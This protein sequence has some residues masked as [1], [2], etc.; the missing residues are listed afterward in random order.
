MPRESTAKSAAAP[1]NPP[2]RLRASGGY[3]GLRSFQV[4]T[5]VYDATVV[6]CNSWVNKRSRTHDQMVQAARSGRAGSQFWGCSAY[7]GCKGTRS[8][9]GSD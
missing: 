3:R 6:F 5:L 2:R 7:P 4:T 8:L 9:E 1:G